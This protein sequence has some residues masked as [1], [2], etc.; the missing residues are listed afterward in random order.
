VPTQSD[1]AD[2]FDQ[3][4]TALA[5]MPY[6]VGSHWFE[7]AGEPA[8]GRLDGE[9][10]NYGLVNIKDEPW[11]VLVDRMARVTAG[12]EEVHRASGR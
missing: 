6:A 1:R 12:L 4:V 11:Q 10:G 5:K 2:L 8:E 3:Y 9:N 7:Y